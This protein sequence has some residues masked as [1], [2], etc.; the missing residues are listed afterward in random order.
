M[1]FRCRRSY[2]AVVTPETE[3]FVPCL[4]GCVIAFRTV[5][6]FLRKFTAPLDDIV[7]RLGEKYYRSEHDA[8]CCNILL[9]VV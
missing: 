6:P 5:S 1:R 8:A 4:E 9:S 7:E 3:T 2:R